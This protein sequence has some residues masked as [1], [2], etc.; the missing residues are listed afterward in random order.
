LSHLHNDVI[1]A[2]ECVAHHVPVE[3][4]CD[5]LAKGQGSGREHHQATI[6]QDQDPGRDVRILAQQP[7]QRSPEGLKYTVFQRLSRVGVVVLLLE[8]LGGEGSHCANV[9]REHKGALLRFPCV[10]PE[11]ILANGHFNAC[12]YKC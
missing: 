9:L 5:Q 1:E 11:P 12:F 8:P 6:P 10:C 2:V 3:L 4:E 7:L